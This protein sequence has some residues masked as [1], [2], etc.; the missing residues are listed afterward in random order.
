VLF[1]STPA[2][3]V[4][5]L[6]STSLSVVTAPWLARPRR[7]HRDHPYGTSPV[8]SNG[9]DQF[10]YLALPTVTGVSP[11]SGPTAGGNTVT[12]TGTGFRNIAGFPGV[13][14]VNFGSVPAPSFNVVGQQITATVPLARRVPSMSPS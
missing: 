13:L 3:S 2:T 9:L 8:T 6:S 1:G 4:T 7:C 5:V 14:E 10:T 12:I 11:A